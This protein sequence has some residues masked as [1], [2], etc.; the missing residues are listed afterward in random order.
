MPID[1][2]EFQSLLEQVR[3]LHLLA[4]ELT[5]ETSRLHANVRARMSWAH[6]P[7]PLPPEQTRLAD[8]AVEALSR[9]RLSSSQS[10]H[11]Q[12]AFFGK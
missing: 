1:D 6:D 3:A 8:E 2:R 10:R 5:R 12:R 7:P 4:D 9:P 11:L